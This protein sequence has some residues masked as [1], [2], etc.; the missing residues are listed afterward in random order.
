MAYPQDWDA[1]EVKLKDFYP[2]DLERGKVRKKLLDFDE[3]KALK[4]FRDSDAAVKATLDE[5]LN[6]G[7]LKQLC[8]RHRM[9]QPPPCV[10]VHQ[11]QRGWACEFGCSAGSSSLSHALAADLAQ[12]AKLVSSQD[13]ALPRSSCICTV[14]TLFLRAFPFSSV[15]L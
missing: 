3:T 14:A 6:E 5:L 8:H 12:P 9:P 10:C 13:T 7:E 1:A 4:Y 2:N 15:G 11:L